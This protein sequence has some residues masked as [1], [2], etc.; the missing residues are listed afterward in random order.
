MK[1]SSSVF[2]WIRFH[3][4]PFLPKV[5]RKTGLPT[6]YFKVLVVKVVCRICLS[7]S[8]VSV[9][10]LPYPSILYTCLS[11]SF[12]SM[13]KTW[14]F[15]FIFSTEGYFLDVQRSEHYSLFS[16][17]GFLLDGRLWSSWLFSPSGFTVFAGFIS[18]GRGPST[19]HRFLPKKKQLDLFADGHDCPMA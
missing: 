8:A 9:V 18:S 2:F 15:L 3:S 11:G 6:C 13:P 5:L 17:G 7:Y 16:A 14:W 10:H 19:T 4:I 1:S 12:Y